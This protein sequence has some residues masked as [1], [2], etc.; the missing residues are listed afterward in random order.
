MKKQKLYQEYR[1][2]MDFLSN[3]LDS[4]EIMVLG[5]LKGFN[6]KTMKEWQRMGL[7]D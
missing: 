2:E 3:Q 7:Y 4:E 5:Y 6:R 1:Q